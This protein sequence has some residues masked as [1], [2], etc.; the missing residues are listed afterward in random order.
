M[1]D[2][3]HLRETVRVLG[4]R[5]ITLENERIGRTFRIDR[6]H[7]RVEHLEETNRQGW[8]P[9]HTK[10]CNRL[11]VL[12]LLQTADHRSLMHLTDSTIKTL[13]GI[14]LL[15]DGLDKIAK[16]GKG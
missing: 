4:N 11:E 14:I 6:M 1:T 12:E 3:Q 15:I 10:V 7:T 13:D 9:K 2:I 8:T 16:G 5:M